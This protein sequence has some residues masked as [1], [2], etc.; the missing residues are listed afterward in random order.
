VGVIAIVRARKG[1]GREHPLHKAVADAIERALGRD[2]ELVRDP[3]CRGQ[4][5]IPL[6][7]GKRK[8]RD[9]RMCCVDLL[10]LVG[11]HVRAMVEIEESGFLPTKIC[12]KFLQAALADHFIHD[13]RKEGPVPYGEH[14][15]FVQVF[16]G[17]GCLKG[18]SRKEQQARLIE[19]KIRRLLPLRGLSD[20]RLFFVNGAADEVGL[21]AVAT[22]V[23]NMLAEA[24]HP[25]DKPRC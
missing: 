5:Q 1:K 23:S 9:T 22:A 17:L 10:L 21:E 25:A 2:V 16:D 8:A 11:G 7:V 12:G 19:A 6:F 18:G 24:P 3:A 15:L 13:T 4:Q 14:V 20:Y